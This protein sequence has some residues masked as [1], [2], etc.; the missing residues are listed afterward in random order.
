MCLCGVCAIGVYV[1]AH[2]CMCVEVCSHVWNKTFPPLFSEV[3]TGQ[4]LS[5]NPELTL[6]LLVTFFW[7]AAV[8]L[9]SVEFP[10]DPPRPP[11]VLWGCWWFKFSLRSL[12]LMLVQST[13]YLPSHLPSPFSML[14]VWLLKSHSYLATDEKCLWVIRVLGNFLRWA[15]GVIPEKNG[16]LRMTPTGR[17]LFLPPSGFPL[18]SKM[19][20][21]IVSSQS[22]LPHPWYLYFVEQMAIC[23]ALEPAAHLVT[24]WWTLCLRLTLGKWKFSN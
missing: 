5:F 19:S 2:V 8:C 9:Q 16:T 6:A 10:G 22:L 15:A 18:F 11:G 20:C 4:S 17:R 12:V 14:Y 1:W 23:S 21:H 13:I 24:S 3:C 7:A